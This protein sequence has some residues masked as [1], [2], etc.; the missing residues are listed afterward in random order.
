[1]TYVN[2]QRYCSKG[3]QPGYALVLG[4]LSRLRQFALDFK[5]QTHRAWT[6]FTAHLSLAMAIFNRLVQWHGLQ[7]DENGFVALSIA[8]FGL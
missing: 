7:P 1:M 5:Q 6:Y 8:Q 2:F 4:R 3:V